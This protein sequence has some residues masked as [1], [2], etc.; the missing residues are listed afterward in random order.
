MK[1]TRWSKKAKALTLSKAKRDDFGE[2]GKYVNFT[3]KN[4]KKG[5]GES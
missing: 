4:G 1:S 5:F 3:D 2:V